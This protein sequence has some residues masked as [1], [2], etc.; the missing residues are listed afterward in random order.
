MGH[1]VIQP[2]NNMIYRKYTSETTNKKWVAAVVIVAVAV[3]TEKMA[4]VGC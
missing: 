1:Q 2:V 4:E 3:L